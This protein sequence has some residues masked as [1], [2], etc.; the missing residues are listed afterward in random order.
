MKKVTMMISY[1]NDLF[2][3]VRS[4]GEELQRN[5]E[6]QWSK[7]LTDALLISSAPGEILGETRS[8]LRL[9]LAS[10]VA[11]KLDLQ[12]QISEAIDYLNET[13]GS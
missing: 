9:I 10:E 11:D 6:T 13:L 5:G 3:V 4:L 12:R 8:Q 7:A 2:A 1:N